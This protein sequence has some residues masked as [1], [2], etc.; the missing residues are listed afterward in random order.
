MICPVHENN[1]SSHLLLEKMRIF[2]LETMVQVLQVL[3]IHI[4]AK[5]CG[6][7]RYNRFGRFIPTVKIHY[8]KDEYADA[9]LPLLLPQN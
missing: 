3:Q 1:A 4:G 8:K 6:Y 5:L 9:D 2:L 7:T